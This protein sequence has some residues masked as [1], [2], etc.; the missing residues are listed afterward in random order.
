MH[1]HKL[2]TR[3]QSKT[4]RG[5]EGAVSVWSDC[6]T[7]RNHR[8]YITLVTETSLYLCFLNVLCCNV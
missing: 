3:C 1:L 8:E 6:R 7:W 2:T 4:V 5:E